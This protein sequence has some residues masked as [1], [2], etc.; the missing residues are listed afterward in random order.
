VDG[1]SRVL[2][3]SAPVGE[4]HVAAA[5]ALAARMRALWPGAR[6]REVES[7]GGAHRDRLIRT[8]YA[9]T[10][11]RA[12]RLYGLG[13]DLLVRFP[14]AAALFKA[15]TAARLGRALGP[16]VDAERPDLVVSTYPMISGGLA[17]LRRRGRL[18]GRAVVVVTDVAV[19]PFWVWADLDETWTLLPA[20]RDQARAVAPGADAIVAPPVVAPAFRPGDRTAAR[21]AA[22]LPG[23]AFVVLLS[24][25]SLGFGALE[26]LV[27]AVLAAA[28]GVTAVVL[29]GHNDRLRARLARRGLPAERLVAVGWTDRMP[30]LVTAADLVLTTAGGVTATEAL[31]VGRPV[32]FAAPVPGH[33]RAGAAMTADAG[34]GIVCP[35]PV[36]V[37]ATVR[38]LYDAPDELAALARRTAAFGERDLDAELVALAHRLRG[39][40]G[41]S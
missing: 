40:R 7:T 16:L 3:L 12:P 24:G 15:L 13:Y 28:P 10:M 11:R 23:D 30:E 38:R 37:T 39:G 6:I 25:G 18:P 21:A 34:L 8:A 5:R 14:R 41:G 1:P 29:C 2:V 19:H 32:L 22:G 35:R 17:W 27:D 31:A 4:G 36:D 26:P 33:G 20:S 9:V